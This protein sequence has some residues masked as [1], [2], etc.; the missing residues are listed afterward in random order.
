[1][2]SVTNW[3]KN[4][5]YILF[6]YH[7]EARTQILALPDEGLPTRRYSWNRKTPLLFLPY[8]GVLPTVGLAAHLAIEELSYR[9]YPQAEIIAGSVSSGR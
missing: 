5:V 4:R 7:A 6:S 8:E 2:D 9:A 3:L 1:M